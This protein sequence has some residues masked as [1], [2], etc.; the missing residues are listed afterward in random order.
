MLNDTAVAVFSPS[1]VKSCSARGNGI[2]EFV[3][4]IQASWPRYIRFPALFLLL[5]IQSAKSQS[6]RRFREN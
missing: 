6:P 2:D 1:H 4:T 3:S 5:L